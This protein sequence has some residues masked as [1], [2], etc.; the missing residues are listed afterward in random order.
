HPAVI[1][2]SLKQAKS[3]DSMVLI[4]S[5]SNQVNQDGGY[6]GMT[7]RDFVSYVGQ[8][9]E[10]V[11]YPLNRIL[12]GGDHL[13][14]NPWSSQS[15][16]EAMANARKLVQ[17]YAEAGF[18]KIH[19]D[20][21]MYCADDVG[22]R[23]KPLPDEVVAT[24]A[25]ELCGVVEKTWKTSHRSTP[26]PVYIIGTE[27]PVPG[28]A[29]EAEDHVEVT[30]TADAL[31]TI[32]VTRDRFLR[33]GLEDAW[34]R[35][36]GLVVQPGVEFGDDQVFD[37]QPDAAAQLSAAIAPYPGMVYE[38]HSTDYQTE[39][40]LEN[41]VRDHFCI[42]K[43]GPWL[44]YAYREALFALEAIEREVAPLHP[45]STELSC[46]SE[47][48]D[49]VMEADPQ[50]W[51]KY[52]PGDAGEQAFKRKYS[53]SDRSRYYW[54]DARLQEACS[55]LFANLRSWGIPPSV[56]SQFMPVKYRQ[57]REGLVTADPADLALARVRDVIAM[58]ARACGMAKDR[59]A[60]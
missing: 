32:E 45:G 20:A 54:P 41:L 39:E 3:D 19:L 7:P 34:S 28:G 50:F 22:D 43:V 4:E 23:A 35:V 21:S 12:F 25:A 18:Q 59:P 46:L 57:V 56:L 8:I 36:C 37:Y 55:R 44:T 27:V 9:A 10:T 16:E 48:L 47:A 26:P 53:Y 1:E 40:G 24:R 33:S 15:A 30:A 6:T 38:A 60:C 11:G 52:Y 42:L 49:T 29:Q 5:T 58:Y 13:G 51:K 17:H 2:A 14:P 31:R